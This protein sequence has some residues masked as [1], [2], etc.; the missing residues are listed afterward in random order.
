[1]ETIELWRSSGEHSQL[2]RAHATWPRM[3]LMFLQ[4]VHG[5]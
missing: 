5:I 3:L 1:M 2:A 4:W